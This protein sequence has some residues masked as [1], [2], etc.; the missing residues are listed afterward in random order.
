MPFSMLPEAITSPSIIR[1]AMPHGV[2][3]AVISRALMP[4]INTAGVH[5]T[6]ILVGMSVRINADG[7]PKRIHELKV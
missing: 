6:F 4:S 3:S 5:P 1:V 7:S 2:S